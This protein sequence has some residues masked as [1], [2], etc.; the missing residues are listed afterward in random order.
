MLTQQQIQKRAWPLFIVA[1]IVVFGAGM[2]V[3]LYLASRGGVQL[4]D[5]DYYERGK[6]YEHFA[7]S[8]RTAGRQGLMMA[9]V[10]GD[11]GLAVTVTDG[12]GKAAAKGDVRYFA[13]E[14]DHGPGVLL[15]EEGGGCYLLPSSELAPS[16][17]GR[18]VVTVG[19]AVL[20]EKIR[21]IGR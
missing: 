21:V 10:Q 7:R 16:G 8:D 20:T 12:S 13:S 11:S 3:T 15:R 2:A 9:L 18:I 14:G 5:A 6:N 4:V 19:N 1:I 17:R